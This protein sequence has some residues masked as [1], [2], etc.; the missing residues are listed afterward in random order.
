MLYNKELNQIVTVCTESMVRV[1]ETETGKQVYQIA[2]AHGPT[3]EVTAIALDESGYRLA[4]GAF[5]GKRFK[6]EL[7]GRPMES[8]RRWSI[9]NLST[10]LR[11]HAHRLLFQS[12]LRLGVHQKAAVSQ[13]KNFCTC[14]RSKKILSERQLTSTSY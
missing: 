8:Q 3:V 12:F 13:N 1:W 4:S 11:L 7:R 2:E 6:R 14:I 9:Y 10:K 5:D